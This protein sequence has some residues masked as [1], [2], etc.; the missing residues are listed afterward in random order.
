MNIRRQKIPTQEQLRKAL[1]DIGGEPLQDSGFEDE[2]ADP[3][4]SEQLR[5][6]TLPDR[7]DDQRGS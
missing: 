6:L 4:F 2:A 5:V 7:P 3:E 1:D